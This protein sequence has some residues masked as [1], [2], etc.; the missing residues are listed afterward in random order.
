MSEGELKE[1]TCALCG[2]VH[3]KPELSPKDT[4]W[5]DECGCSDAG[6]CSKHQVEI[7]A[8]FRPSNE[9]LNR[10]AH[11]RLETQTRAWYILSHKSNF[12]N[13]IMD[14]HFLHILSLLPS[15][16]CAGKVLVRLKE[17]LKCKERLK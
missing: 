9:V 4:P 2:V 12:F 17:M 13:E 14:N 15:T 6:L 3:K 5:S 10:R 11:L 16:S 1:V 7:V 8:P